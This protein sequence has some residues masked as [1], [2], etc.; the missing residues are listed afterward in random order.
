LT[1]IVHSNH[2]YK[3]YWDVFVVFLLVFVCIVI[4]FRLTFI[5]QKSD[6]NQRWEIAYYVIDGMFGVDIVLTFFTSIPDEDKM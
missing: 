1:W 2:I 3:I 5:P 4:P 6:D